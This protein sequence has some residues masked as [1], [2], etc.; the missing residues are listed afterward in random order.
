[1]RAAFRAPRETRP[2]DAG[3]RSGYAGSMSSPRHVCAALLVLAAA[4]RAQQ[5]CPFRLVAHPADDALS[6]AA[7]PVLAATWQFAQ[8]LLGVPRAEV[9]EMIVHAYASRDDYIAA[10]EA[11]DGP[12]PRVFPGFASFS[13]RTAHLFVGDPALRDG[14]LSPMAQDGVVHEVMHLSTQAIAGRHFSFEKR[15]Y[16]EGLAMWAEHCLHDAKRADVPEDNSGVRDI[17]SAARA[18]TLL[19][20]GR[21]AKVDRILL[22]DNGDLSQVDEYPVH[23]VLFGLL[24]EEH[25]DAMRRFLATAVALPSSPA[26]PQQH[27]DLLRGG[28][29]DEAWRSLDGALEQRILAMAEGVP[30]NAFEP[31]AD[32]HGAPGDDDFHPGSPQVAW[33]GAHERPRLTMTVNVTLR[34]AGND[35]TDF[36][37]GQH[38]GSWLRVCL[39]PGRVLV[40][41]RAQDG[42]ES[43]GWQVLARSKQ[44]DTPAIGRPARLRIQAA[45]GSVT[46]QLDGRLAVRAAIGTRPVRGRWGMGAPAGCRASWKELKLR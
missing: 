16:V 25:G 45:P 20:D 28:L 17:Y 23:R 44:L 26:L 14:A 19:R 35:Q 24:M 30:E 1:M 15:W 13:T 31:P 5:P 38:E 36:V 7:Q 37:F 33:A 42:D 46:V 32:L 39:V 2:G 4:L 12:D 41:A 22:G 34:R 40:L 3:D 21:I 27:V 10:S 18:R 11:I 9:P 29:G 6:V 43:G 8:Q